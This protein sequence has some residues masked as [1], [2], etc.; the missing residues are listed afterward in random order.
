MR[1]LSE[2]WL[3]AAQAAKYAGVGR[4]RLKASG[5]PYEFHRG[6][7]YY[8]RADLDAYGV[9]L[10]ATHRRA[11]NARRLFTVH[12]RWV[13]GAGVSQPMSKHPLY[14]THRQMM[15]RCYTGR[16]NRWD[17][18]GGRGIT[19]H[20]PWHDVVVFIRE[21]ETLIGPRPAGHSLDRIDPN[22]HYEPGNVRW[23]DAKGQARNRRDPRERQ[24]RTCGCGFD[25]S[26]APGLCPIESLPWDRAARALALHVI[27][28]PV[29]TRPSRARLV[30]HLHTGS[31]IDCFACVRQD[32]YRPDPLAE[33]PVSHH[34]WC[35]RAAGRPYGDAHDAV[36]LL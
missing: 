31:Y 22:G 18:Y 2:E 26:E 32:P 17:N 23:L 3:S 15:D 7:R 27:R 6:R 30:Q 1:R 12:E 21:I 10:A 20:E 5:V 29:V 36:F 19:V 13:D 24:P 25:C 11:D 33:E 8:K 14:N 35:E 28:V 9:Q 16:T 4:A 34:A